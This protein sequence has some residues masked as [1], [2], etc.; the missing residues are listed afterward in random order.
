LNDDFSKI[1]IMCLVG[2]LTK[3]QKAHYIDVFVNGSPG[4]NPRFLVATSGA[5]NAG[6]DCDDVY[7][8]YRL[9]FPPSRIDLCQEKGH[10]GRH[11]FEKRAITG[12]SKNR[13]E[14]GGT[15]GF[16]LRLVYI[17]ICIICLCMLYWQLG[18]AERAKF[19]AN[20]PTVGG[21]T[22]AVH[23]PEYACSGVGRQG[24]S[25]K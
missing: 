23:S 14:S 8:V 20:A 25:T 17:G 6:I 9:D 3:E 18:C 5:V 15:Q 19:G 2:T 24:W 22:S 7:G 11:S 13:P 16:T 1:D 21:Q 10:V 4:F 12:I